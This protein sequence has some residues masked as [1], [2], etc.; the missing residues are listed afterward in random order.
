MENTNRKL[1]C[2]E[3]A[4]FLG[5]S[6]SWLAK[7]RVTGGGPPYLK[8]GKRVL[9]EESDLQLWAMSRRRLHT[10]DAPVITESAK[11]S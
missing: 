1:S 10:S 9:Y 7:L 3:A 6:R 4:S 5:L 2:D 11:A 8:I